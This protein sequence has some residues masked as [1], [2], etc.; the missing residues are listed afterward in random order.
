MT[1]PL[2]VEDSAVTE[3]PAPRSYTFCQEQVLSVQTVFQPAVLT[4][5]SSPPMT[6]TSAFCW[7]CISGVQNRAPGSQSDRRAIPTAAWPLQV[8]VRKSAKV[9]PPSVEEYVAP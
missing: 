5:T 9:C 1:L 4:Q 8:G 3:L 2:P 7:S 6:Q